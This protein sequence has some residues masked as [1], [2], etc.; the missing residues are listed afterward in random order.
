MPRNSSNAGAE[1]AAA[2]CVARI[3]AA[4]EKEHDQLLRSVAMLVAKTERPRQVARQVAHMLS[5]AASAMRAASVTAVVDV[6]PQ[7]L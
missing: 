3:R 6:D 2:G 4:V 7:E 5:A 1:S